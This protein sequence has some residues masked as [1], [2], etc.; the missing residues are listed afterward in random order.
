MKCYFAYDEQTGNRVLIPGCYGSLHREDKAMCTC[1]DYPSYA[2]TFSQYEKQVY[3]EEIKKL[4]NIIKELESDNKH[5]YG[6]NSA[7]HRVII[8]LKKKVA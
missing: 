6:E 2:N 1:N 7:L 5:L 8:K 4:K 3:N